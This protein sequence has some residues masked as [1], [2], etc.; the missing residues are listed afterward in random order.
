MEWLAGRELGCEGVVLVLN[1]H[2]GVGGWWVEFG[3]FKF[4]RDVFRRGKGRKEQNARK[5]S[6]I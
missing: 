2:V 5:R 1:V 3:G 6:Q 4:H